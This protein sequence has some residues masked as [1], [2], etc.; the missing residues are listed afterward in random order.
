[1]DVS[2]IQDTINSEFFG[3]SRSCHELSEL[4]CQVHMIKRYKIAG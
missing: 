3:D 2:F 4:V 1:M